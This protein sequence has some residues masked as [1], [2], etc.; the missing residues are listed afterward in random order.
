MR[1]LWCCFL[2]L[3]LAASGCT[4]KSKARAQAKAAFEAGA[5]QRVAR[6]LAPGEERMVNIMGQVRNHTVPWE[7]GMTVAN[8]LD[9]AVYTGFSD[10]RLIVLRRGAESVQIRVRDLLHGTDNPLVE[11]EDIIEIKR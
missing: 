5:K 3:A 4:T 9:A 8:A 10:P 1:L 6:T 7:E 2:V 11:P